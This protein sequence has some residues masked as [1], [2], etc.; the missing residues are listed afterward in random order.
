[1]TDSNLNTRSILLVEDEIIIAMSEKNELE[2]Y[3]YRVCTVHTGKDAIKI[4]SEKKVPV[5]LVLMDIDLGKGMDGTEA[6]REILKTADIPILFLS[7]HR[8]TE[9]VQKAENITSYGY[10]IKNSG[11]QVLDASIKMAFRLFEAKDRIADIALFPEQNENPVFRITPDSVLLYANKAARKIFINNPDVKPGEKIGKEWH[12]RVR[13]IW[14]HKKSINELITLGDSQ[15]LF[16]VVPIPERNY[17]NI[18]A[19]DISEQIKAENSL[20]ESEQ[21]YSAIVNNSMIGIALI[22][23]MEILF[24]NKKFAETFGYSA[25]EICAK[26]TSQLRQ[27]AHPDDLDLLVR[28]YRDRISGKDTPQMY[29][30]RCLHRDGHVIWV[31]ISVDVI[32]YNGEKAVQAYFLDISK[33]KEASESLRKSEERF[34]NLADNARDM[35]YRMSIP[36]GKY[37]YVS[38]ASESIFGYTPEDFYKNPLLLNEVIHPA[39]K[40]YFIN[41]WE[42]CKKGKIPETYEY[43][44]L[45]KDG[46]EKWLNQHNVNIKDDMG[47]TIAIEGIVSDNTENKIYELNLSYRI[48]VE[49]LISDVALTVGNAD[50]SSIDKAIEDV[51]GKIAAFCGAARANLFRFEDDLTHFSSTHEWVRHPEDSQIKRL[52]KVPLLQFGWHWE[53]ILSSGRSA[54]SWQLDYPPEAVNELEWIKNNGFHPVLFV[55][56]KHKNRPVGAI[57]LFGGLDT[58]IDWPE[59][60]VDAMH[61]ISNVIQNSLERVSAENSAREALKQNQNLLAE[62]QHRAK[63][64]FSMISGMIFLAAE[65]YAS[66]EL[67][68]VLHTLKAKTDAISR[69]YELLYSANSVSQVRLDKYLEMVAASIPVAS[70]SI[71][72]ERKLIPVTMQVK[73]AISV[74]IITAELLTNAIKHAFPDGGK[75]VV[76]LKTEKNGNNI[77]VQVSDNG[78]GFSADF[79]P[80]K[81]DS[82]GLKLVRALTEQLQGKLSIKNNKGIRVLLTFEDIDPDSGK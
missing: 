47:K 71:R 34:R 6:A 55:A 64:S 20:H 2:K 48:N 7:S 72:I 38:P 76:L 42:D 16:I 41:K 68:S 5:D 80:E 81:T 51:L 43:K 28:N 21:Q 46:S 14:L 1:M 31:E 69:M 37:E 61:S 18:Y 52:Q 74:G 66:A 32:E 53:N 79:D 17:L 24:C 40:D 75:G 39:W 54:V 4:V 19:T 35:I 26:T 25:D 62:L 3:G 63:N 77:T 82:L 78:K 60:F 56:I 10:V 12:E 44:I 9:I 30:V 22:R 33:R 59:Y 73:K 29:E 11:I 57:G 65:S 67:K 58:V 49:H 45:N 50:Y 27:M 23:D 70:D 8:E 13:K 36:D 15:Y